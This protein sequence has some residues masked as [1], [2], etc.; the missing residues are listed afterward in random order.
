MAGLS[1]LRMRAQ[2]FLFAKGVVHRLTFGARGA[3]VNGEQVL[4]IRHTYVPGWHFPGGG[5]DPGE[6]AEA[7]FRR[8]VF[9]ETGYRVVGPATLFGLYHN[10]QA[11]NRD[12]VALYV[13]H[14]F[15]EGRPFRPSREIAE[16]GWFDRHALPVDVSAC[17][18]Q[19]IAELFGE[20]PQR[21]EW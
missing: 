12:H 19:R 8:E 20:A 6:T 7:A 5:V 3:L 16:M 14:D 15:E 4:L 11:T 18:R 13:S 17:T 2:V 10:V 9:E 1:W 21:P